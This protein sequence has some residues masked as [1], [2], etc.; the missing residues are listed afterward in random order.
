MLATIANTGE[1]TCLYACVSPSRLVHAVDP[2]AKNIRLL[3]CAD[4]I[5]NVRKARLALSAVGGYNITGPGKGRGQQLV[6]GSGRMRPSAHGDVPVSTVDELFG[7]STAGFMHIDVEGRMSLTYFWVVAE[8]SVGTGPSSAWRLIFVARK[9][10]T[11]SCSTTSRHCSTRYSWC[12]RS[13]AGLRTAA[14][15]FA[16]PTRGSAASPARRCSVLPCA[17]E[18]SLR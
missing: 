7:D 2:S 14:T 8:L 3:R 16:S 6:I 13:V 1:W 10:A 4:H 18:C 9:R 11:K 15:C 12:T 5:Q 17:A